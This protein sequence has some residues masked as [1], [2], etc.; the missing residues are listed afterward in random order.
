MK[1]K[2]VTDYS[3][4]EYGGGKKA[5]IDGIIATAEK[6]A[7]AIINDATAQ[8]A[9][10]LE[11]TRIECERAFKEQ[12]R[13]AD[14][15][16]QKMVERARVTASLETRKELLKSKRQL[17][18]KVYDAV[19]EKILN[20][21]NARYQKLILQSALPY[22]EDGDEVVISALD[23]KRLNSEWVLKLSKAS[24]K[25]VKLSTE[26]HN[27]SGGVILRSTSYDKNVTIETIINEVKA[28][29][30][31]QVSTRLFDER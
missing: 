2:A 28:K 25:K 26:R 1:N 20:L 13:I 29:T 5:I 21:T 23:E 7:S 12:K 11:K 18:D 17:I 9:T 14:E 31:T 8:Q 10:A 15:T 3:T 22:V 16:A 19:K 30:E 4:Q 24:G 6:N 27:F